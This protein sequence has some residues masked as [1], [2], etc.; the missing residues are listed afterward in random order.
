MNG[1][2]GF[3][4]RVSHDTSPG[5]RVVV[6]TNHEDTTR[7]QCIDDVLTQNALA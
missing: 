1:V 5:I 6:L 2:D 3:M 4:S 7:V